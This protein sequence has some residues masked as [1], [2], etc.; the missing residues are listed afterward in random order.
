[1]MK[2]YESR[3]TNSWKEFLT[4]IASDLEVDTIGPFP[5]DYLEAF[6]GLWAD[7]GFQM[8]ILKTHKFELHDDL[9]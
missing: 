8:V 1:M 4:L 2:L 5:D 7:Q 9:S 3:S 6:K